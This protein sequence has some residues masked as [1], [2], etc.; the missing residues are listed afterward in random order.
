[1]PDDLEAPFA[2]ELEIYAADGSTVIETSTSTG[3]MKRGLRELVDWLLRDNPVPAG[4]ILY[5]GTG[6]V[7]PDDVALAPGMRTVVRIPGIGELR[8]PVHAAGDL[9]RKLG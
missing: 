6:I 7:P 5:T 1:M 3:S 9:A 2:I 4:S 8:N